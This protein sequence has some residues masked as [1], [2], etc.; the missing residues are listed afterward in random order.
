MNNHS[1]VR[2][3]RAEWSGVQCEENRMKN[4]TLKDTIK[5]LIG[6]SVTLR[7]AL[8]KKRCET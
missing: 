7:I 6:D 2:N 3:E 1:R 8:N 5:K 4:T